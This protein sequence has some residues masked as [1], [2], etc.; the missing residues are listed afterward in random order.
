L[1]STA[2]VDMAEE[3]AAVAVVSMGVGAR[4]AVAVEKLVKA[5]GDLME[6][7][8]TAEAAH[9]KQA[10]IQ[11]RRRCGRRI[12]ARRIFV[13]PSTMANGIRSAMVPA[14]LDL[15]VQAQDG[16]PQVP[17]TQPSSLATPEWPMGVGTPLADRPAHRAEA[18]QEVKAASK[19]A[20]AASQASIAAALAFETVSVD[21]VV[22]E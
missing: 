7:E 14:P 17:R 11:A 16:I 20:P 12:V 1:L 2:V 9:L 3:E 15:R 18:Q 8:A 10:A 6:E 13:Q 19:A 21:G 4:I 5:V 22:V